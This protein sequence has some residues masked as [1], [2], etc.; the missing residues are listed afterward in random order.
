MSFASAC[1][2]CSLY[3]WC[4]PKNHFYTSFFCLLSYCCPNSVL[5]KHLTLYRSI[6]PIDIT[7]IQVHLTS[8]LS[9]LTQMYIFAHNSIRPKG[10]RLEW[11]ADTLWKEGLASSLCNGYLKWESAKPSQT[12]HMLLVY[13][14]SI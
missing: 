6:H 9:Q 14:D 13:W 10:V 4:L 7:I 12:Y 11:R 8:T 3:F 2:C 5:N 1:H